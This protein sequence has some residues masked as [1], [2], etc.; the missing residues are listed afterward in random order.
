[1]DADVKALLEQ[2]R[3]RYQSRDFAG[4]EKLL[5]RVRV[6]AP[7][8]ADVHNMLGLIFHDQ[9]KFGKALEAF[10]EAL[11]INPAYTEARLNLAVTYNDLGMY[12]EAR[13]VFAKAKTDNKAAGNEIDPFV[14][15][16]LANM[17]A[18]LGDIYAEIQQW[19]PAVSEYKKAIGL[20]PDF[21]DIRTS[22]GKTL[23]E[24]GLKEESKKELSEAKKRNPKYSPAGVQLGI[25]YFSMGK[26]ADAVAEWKAVLRHDPENPRAKM[27]LKLAEE[28]AKTKGARK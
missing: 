9:G 22:L 16:K 6:T 20:R 24:A 14:K 19:A 4:A 18:D 12:D 26:N 17:H 8:F 23:R 3:E 2:G 28:M 1:V 7:A 13:A 5:E 21:A 25:T 10:Q 15:G 27:F 11:K